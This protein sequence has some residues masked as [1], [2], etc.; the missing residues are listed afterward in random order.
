MKT[1]ILLRHS[2]KDG[3]NDTIGPKGLKLAWEQGLN[4]KEIRPEVIFHGPLVRTAQTA[5]AF[6]EGLGYVP[7]ITPVIYGLGDSTLFAEIATPE[8]RTAAK[9]TSFFRAT[10]QTHG[11]EKTKIWAEL[12]LQAVKSMFEQMDDDE[13]KL[14]IGFFH[15]P[16]IEL[17]AWACG[18]E[19]SGIDD[20]DKFSEMEGLT[21]KCDT[22]NKFMSL[23]KSASLKTPSPKAQKRF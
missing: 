14:A 20:W 1:L 9:S 5:L 13:N 10:L 3:P 18:V 12:G 15:S 19:Q 11:V 21:F 2:L 8:F 23:I 6:C 17:A 16:T 22:S 7:R 4:A